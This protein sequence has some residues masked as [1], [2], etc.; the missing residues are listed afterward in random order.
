MPSG[1]RASRRGS[2]AAKR[3]RKEI[4]EHERK[5]KLATGVERTK[6][7]ARN[8]SYLLGMGLAIVAG[9]L[10]VLVL[11]ATL[12]NGIARWNAERAEDYERSPEA[13]AEMA[14]DN[15]LFIA[16]TDGTATGFLAI[17]WDFEQEAVYGIA[18]PDGAFLEVPGYGFERIGDS[19]QSGADVSMAAVSNFFGV[20]FTAYAVVDTEI[21]QT[22]LTTQNLN[23]IMEQVD[24]TNLTEVE[25]TR[26]TEVLDSTPSESVALVPMPVKPISVGSQTYFEPLREEV[27]DLVE[28]WW[29]STM[30]R[31]DEAVTVIVYNGAG[32][33]GIAGIA[34][35]E[36]I[37]SGLRVVDT[38]NADR[39]DYE[40]TQIVVQNGDEASGEAVRDVLGVGEMVM[41]PADQEVAD[42]IVIIGKDYTGL[43]QD[44]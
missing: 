20:P 11:V 24:E 42:V 30:A 25:Q 28:Q 2:R 10:L 44:Q 34:A 4:K 35:Q 39:F 14:K 13:L 23:G 1:W 6:R 19:Y 8:V 5:E 9:S 33:A 43:S 37:R 40:T 29:G 21:Y 41:Q 36:L 3:A 27:A 17:R 15:L 7:G 12:I 38:K 26:W 31:D 16:E 22:A 32:T 18:I